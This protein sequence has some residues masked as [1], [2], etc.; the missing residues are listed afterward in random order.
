LH[1]PFGGSFLRSLLLLLIL[2][3]VDLHGEGRDAT[4]DFVKVTSQN[5][6]LQFRLSKPGRVLPTR[7]KFQRQSFKGKASKARRRSIDGAMQQHAKINSSQ[8]KK[9]RAA[10]AGRGKTSSQGGEKVVRP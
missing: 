6:V 10:G 4:R 2:V 5:L 9:P 3:Q 8:K 7:S 1:D